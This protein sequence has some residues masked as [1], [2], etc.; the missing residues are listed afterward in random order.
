LLVLSGGVSNASPV[1]LTD[2]SAQTG[3]GFVHE[4]GRSGRK[5]YIETLGSGAA[6]FDYNRDGFADI[7]LVNG[8]ELPGKELA[9]PPANALYRNNGD[10]TFTDVT[11]KA[12]VGDTHYGFGCA[13]GDFDNDGWDDLYVTN[14]GPNNLYRNNGN[15]TFT[16]VAVSSGVADARWGAAAA[17][18]DFDNDGNLDLY[19]ANY[20]EFDVETNPPCLK[21]GVRLH[22][23]PDAFRG[24]PGV[25][26]RNRGDGT[27]E[28]VT[29]VAGVYNPDDKGMGVAWCDYDND[30]DAD[31]FVANDRVANRFY[32]NNGDGT[33]T[34]LALMSGIAYGEMGNVQ[35]NMAP[36]FGDVDNDGWFDLVITNFHDEPNNLYHNDGDG[37][38]SDVSYQSRLGGFG[39]SLLSW[40]A[41]FGDFD[42]DGWL[43]LFV[44]NG[45]L[46]DNIAD[47]MPNLT[48]EQPNELY[49]N[50]G[51]GVFEN[52]SDDAGDGMR[53]RRVSRGVA[54]ADMDND[55]D[56]DVL[57]TNCGQAPNV[58]RNDTINGNRW[59]SVETVGRRSNR[60]GIGA[61][62]TVVTSG[63]KLIRE[64][65]SGGNYPCQS[66]LR[67]HFGVGFVEV[68][69][70]VEIR[71]PSGQTD[72]YE[73][74]ETNCIYRAVEGGG[75]VPR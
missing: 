16:D 40:G 23:S 67:L 24:V 64:V 61:R 50:V 72:V 65:R 15:G 74:V 49:R 18:A 56:L 47:A 32:R 46:D 34:D 63:R 60:D 7:Y 26:Y 28:D 69:E 57:V 31:L 68:V 9:A 22:C 30:G 45:H 51:G 42:N 4:D 55:G 53:L 1:A 29:R 20:V 58:L 62:V 66:D 14:Y 11:E 10:G 19:L 25:L 5:Y 33:F 70:R 6:W 54:L 48:Y 75:M 59:L 3:I 52:V 41:D 73:N 44:A 36:V 27:F 12:G 35:S 38:F 13:V 21:L 17:F 37:F 8:S 39:L 43:D 71:W 2:V